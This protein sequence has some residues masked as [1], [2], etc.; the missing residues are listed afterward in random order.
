MSETSIPNNNPQ[1]DEWKKFLL[2]TRAPDDYKT[3]F[4]ESNERMSFLLDDGS[5]EGQLDIPSINS[6]LEIYDYI[7]QNPNKAI[8]TLGQADVQK[9]I[10][11]TQKYIYPNWND[12]KTAKNATK[13][14]TQNYLLKYNIPAYNYDETGAGLGPHIK[15]RVGK[16]LTSENYTTEFGVDRRIF[17]GENTSTNLLNNGQFEPILNYDYETFI[18]DVGEK[19]ADKFVVTKN[20]QYRA[21]TINE[22]GDGSIPT[23]SIYNNKPQDF[24]YEQKLV[25]LQYV[26]DENGAYR[27]VMVEKGEEFEGLDIF[28][29]LIDGNYADKPTTVA[30]Q[31]WRDTNERQE[32]E[33]KPYIDK[34]VKKRETE[35]NPLTNEEFQLMLDGSHPD[36]QTDSDLQEWWRLSPS[37]PAN[38][39]ENLMPSPNEGVPVPEFPAMELDKIKRLN[40]A[41][42]MVYDLESG[43]VM[44]VYYDEYAKQMYLFQEKVEKH[45]KYTLDLQ[46][47]TN[48][49]DLKEQLY[50]RY[51][52]DFADELLEGSS[53]FGAMWET[54][55]VWDGIK[56][57]LFN[58]IDLVDQ[59]V[60]MGGLN[61]S[62]QN[63]V[64]FY[65]PEQYENLS[66]KQYRE[67]WAST[68]W[69]IWAK[70]KNGQMVQID[71][72]D[73]NNSQ[74]MSGEWKFENLDT[75]KEYYVYLDGVQLKGSSSYD[76]LRDAF[77]KYTDEA[78][79]TY[80][81]NQARPNLYKVSFNREL[82]GMNTTFADNIANVGTDI[83]GM[84]TGFGGIYKGFSY[85][86]KFNKLSKYSKSALVFTAH[87]NL[88]YADSEVLANTTF[89]D[90]ARNTMFD[91]SIGYMMPVVSNGIVIT[92]GKL[93]FLPR[94]LPGKPNLPMKDIYIPAPQGPILTNE[95]SLSAL[96]NLLIGSG[97]ISTGFEFKELINE[98]I[99][100]VMA[101][102]PNEQGLRGLPYTEWGPVF[103]SK[104]EHRATPEGMKQ[105]F[106]NYSLMT[107][108][109]SS[110][111]VSR[112]VPK[113]GTKQAIKFNQNYKQRNDQIIKEINLHKNEIPSELKARMKLAEQGKLNSDQ[114]HM[115]QTE[116]TIHR[117]NLLINEGIE[118]QQRIQQIEDRIGVDGKRRVKL[119]DG[120]WIEVDGVWLNQQKQI[121]QIL[122]N[123]YQIYR[124][125]Y[126]EISS[127]DKISSKK[128][129]LVGDE[130]GNL[131][132]ETEFTI[133]GRTNAEGVYEPPITIKL[134]DFIV[135][136]RVGDTIVWDKE[137]TLNRI[138]SELPY[139]FPTG[140]QQKLFDLKKF[141]ENR[142]TEVDKRLY[143]LEEKYDFTQNYNDPFK[144]TNKKGE[145]IPVIVN[146]QKSWEDLASMYNIPVNK[147]LSYNGINPENPKDL[148]DGQQIFLENPSGF[149]NVKIE[150]GGPMPQQ[151]GLIHEL[152]SSLL[153]NQHLDITV[154]PH[155]AFFGTLEYLNQHP[156]LEQYQF[157]EADIGGRLRELT[158]EQIMIIQSEYGL[159]IG[160]TYGPNERVFGIQRG[161]SNENPV[162]GQPTKARVSLSED[163]WA[164]LEDIII[165]PVY[166]N[167][168]NIGQEKLLNELNSIENAFRQSV[169]AYELNGMPLPEKEGEFISGLF[170]FWVWKNNLE[171]KMGLTTGNQFKEA[172]ELNPEFA[173][174]LEQWMPELDNTF[175]KFWEVVSVNANG[176]SSVEMMDD[177]TEA[178]AEGMMKHSPSIP[179]IDKMKW[180]DIKSL[181][182]GETY[183]LGVRDYD[184]IIDIETS[185]SP[186]Q[187]TIPQR[188]KLSN[189]SLMELFP[190]NYSVIRPSTIK[191]SNE[192]HLV[193]YLEL[194]QEA[195]DV[196]TEEILN[197]WT[198]PDGLPEGVTKVEYRNLVL[199]NIFSNNYVDKTLNPKYE[200]DMTITVPATIQDIDAKLFNLLNIVESPLEIRE[201]MK[202]E[203]VKNVKEKLSNEWTG[204]KILENKPLSQMTDKEIEE[205]VNAVIEYQKALLN[206]PTSTL[207]QTDWWGNMI[208]QTMSNASFEIP[209]METDKDLKALFHLGLSI[210]SQGTKLDPNYQNT[211]YIISEYLSTGNIPTVK[212]NGMNMD[213]M[214]MVKNQIAKL[215]S[216]KEIHGS[217]ESTLEWLMMPTTVGDLRKY[218]ID[219]MGY[220]KS[221]A[222]SMAQ[223]P[224]GRTNMQLETYN[225]M[226]FGP[227]IGSMI[228]VQKGLDLSVN[229]LWMSRLLQ[230]ATGDIQLNDQQSVQA[231]TIL[232][233]AMDG[234][235]E[236]LG[237]SIKGAQ[238]ETWVNMKDV[239]SLYGTSRDADDYI[240][241]SNTRRK[242]YEDFASSHPLT[243]VDEKRIRR[244]FGR[245]SVLTKSDKKTYLA[246]GE[247]PGE[248][249]NIKPLKFR[250]PFTEGVDKLQEKFPGGEIKKESF[251]N[252]FN[253]VKGIKKKYKEWYDIDGFI[254][255]YEG[256]VVKID[257]FR[258]YINSRKTNYHQVTFDGGVATVDPQ[259]GAFPFIESQWGR[260]PATSVNHQANRTMLPQLRLRTEHKLFDRFVAP[261]LGKEVQKYIFLNGKWKTGKEYGEANLIDMNPSDLKN[262]VYGMPGLKSFLAGEVNELQIRIK[263]DLKLWF[264]NPMP[265]GESARIAKFRSL[266]R[267][268]SEYI[269][270]TNSYDFQVNMQK[271]MIVDVLKNTNWWTYTTGG[272]YSTTKAKNEVLSEGQKFLVSNEYMLPDF[273]EMNLQRIS[274]RD[275]KFHFRFTGDGETTYNPRSATDGLEL[276]L[277][278]RTV[279]NFYKSLFKNH[280]DISTVDYEKEFINA[281]AKAKKDLITSTFF[282]YKPKVIAFDGKHYITY[283]TNVKSLNNLIK[284]IPFDSDVHYDNM[285][286]ELYDYLMSNPQVFISVNNMD[287][288]LNN[289]G[290][291]DKTLGTNG[292]FETKFQNLDNYTANYRGRNYQ[293][294]LVLAPGQKA[295]HID[296]I[297]K[298]FV[299]N[300]LKENGLT[301]ETMGVDAVLRE[302]NKTLMTGQQPVYEGGHWGIQTSLT[303]VRGSEITPFIWKNGKLQ[304]IDHTYTHNIFMVEELQSDWNKAWNQGGQ[305][306]MEPP[307]V[308]GEWVKLGIKNSISNAVKNGNNGITFANGYDIR[309]DWKQNYESLYNHQ[310][311]M[312]VPTRTSDGEYKYRVDSRTMEVLTGRRYENADAVPDYTIEELQ[313]LLGPKLFEMHKDRLIDMLEDIK[314]G[315]GHGAY[316]P[317]F[318]GPIRVKATRAD[319]EF[320]VPDITHLPKP[321]FDFNLYDKHIVSST[322]KILKQFKIKPSVVWLESNQLFGGGDAVVDEWWDFANPGMHPILQGLSPKTKDGK[323]LVPHIYFDFNKG[324]TEFINKDNFETFK[325]KKLEFSDKDKSTIYNKKTTPV[326]DNKNSGYKPKGEVAKWRDMHLRPVSSVLKG[327]GNPVFKRT[328]RAQVSD[329]MLTSSN[330]NSQASGFVRYLIQL[331][332][333][334]PDLFENMTLALYNGDVQMIEKIM[335]ST[336]TELPYTTADYMAIVNLV[337]KVYN[338]TVSLGTE[339]GKIDNYY[340]RSVKDINGLWD[341]LGVEEKTEFERALNKKEKELGRQ[342][343]KEERAGFMDSFLRGYIPRGDGKPGHT[344]GRNINLVTRDMLPYYEKPYDAML[345]YIEMFSKSNS[346]SR[347]FG[348]GNPNESIGAWV[349]EQLV[350]GNIKPGQVDEVKELITQHYAPSKGLGNFGVNLKNSTYILTMANPYSALTQIGDQT[351]SMIETGITRTLYNDV[352]A[353]LGISEV[354]L[355]DLGINKMMH[356]LRTKNRSGQLVSDFFTMSGLTTIDRLGKEALINGTLQKYRELANTGEYDG[357]LKDWKTDKD[358]S[359]LDEYFTPEEKTQLWEDLQSGE[360]TP[361][362]QKLLLNVIMDWQPIADSEV[363]LAY[364]DKPL[365]YQLKTYTIKQVNATKDNL[366]DD[367]TKHSKNLKNSKTEEERKKNKELLE[368]SVVAF[369]TAMATFMMING[370]ADVSKDALAG[371]DID[372]TDI[373]IEQLYKIPGGSRYIQWQIK[374]RGWGEAITKQFLP[375]SWIIPFEVGADV[376]GREINQWNPDVKVGLMPYIQNKRELEKLKKKENKTNIE[377][378]R[379]E[380]LEKALE[381]P[382]YDNFQSLKYLPLGGKHHYW[383]HGVGHK[384]I[385]LR[386]FSK[387]KENA[388]DWYNSK[389]Y[390]EKAFSLEN[391]MDYVHNLDY[392]LSKNMIDSSYYKNNIERAVNYKFYRNMIRST[393]DW[394]WDDVESY[395]KSLD[396]LLDMNIIDFDTW[397][398]RK[399]TDLN[400]YFEE[401]WQ[402]Q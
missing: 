145:T 138:C 396:Q 248:T 34:Y 59:K 109:H 231:M 368:Q 166:K 107:L 11:L 378:K 86:D 33:A 328:V 383:R 387:I 150:G 17:S 375:P 208:E 9:V 319:F 320:N 174:L 289:L 237:I 316:E 97:I 300:Y 149:Y 209:E 333:F 210:T 191:P 309:L 264:E 51:D 147:L 84:F 90:Y 311:L 130:F 258:S 180:V 54:G 217:Y 100:E 274:L 324:F 181:L 57:T 124:T 323:L 218:L 295:L 26:V 292:N 95:N 87:G 77:D 367:I 113:K 121:L 240:T 23:Q 10:N 43:T 301:P 223:A 20:S 241:I 291:S 148:K 44:P 122:D 205:R 112:F 202:L 287:V 110:Q 225:A 47:E 332:N 60:F 306:T 269:Q 318:T 363:P 14:D 144:V 83:A 5:I 388:G 330:W 317:K 63:I 278:S 250:D 185:L 58:S 46:V 310:N 128:S 134:K 169:Q 230:I 65:A 25:V 267:I 203:Q 234:I 55:N 92:R 125:G 152:S 393:T 82:Y 273:T 91:A 281:E 198:P 61:T 68:R 102:K 362:V 355:E 195:L 105:L 354:K 178:I 211:L 325:I 350:R 373:A 397:Y 228:G 216:L 254:N 385:I 235:A 312:I 238:A 394:G 242:N 154:D 296:D 265:E 153:H 261:I 196:W 79:W 384:K 6:T 256:D 349:D 165:E 72:K 279:E 32:K 239:F 283:E 336:N 222:T 285:A 359:R 66:P 304:K 71:T 21:Y 89:G 176:K 206:L 214:G 142:I 347:A 337:D 4:D 13:T 173:Q 119:Q 340:P 341:M 257:D 39:L 200:G 329:A 357:F 201:N 379:M 22:S 155:T 298:E 2:A 64:N 308:T 179:V 381:R 353:L 197:H 380:D 252:E 400:N 136:K 398:R 78:K 29:T 127:S 246:T 28:A 262:I 24:K 244:D 36:I 123:I 53:F 233:K 249:F 366:I 338:E 343:T 369:F 194:N 346:I 49:K 56:G 290:Y 111:Y 229:D 313:K 183:K 70:D 175:G 189:E 276:M 360:V 395:E 280:K 213:R 348:K 133:P 307:T 401:R 69:S 251:L 277:K 271:Q 361:V 371:R 40:D 334:S 212:P 344:K 98:T 221:Q 227:K 12:I 339:M 94:T 3:I 335:E 158:P 187:S 103:Y 365:W 243:G 7:Q 177:L 93:N 351:W 374:D 96:K 157:T 74:G 376:V 156:G 52:K 190:E 75:Y 41:N 322:E 275:M 67:M 42:Y 263:R 377:K 192:G 270:S 160:G 104:L 286:V 294:T 207:S 297:P 352:K 282:G 108:I 38:S 99:D 326:T 386:R 331:E 140:G 120:E 172:L 1:L 73:M 117:Q 302:Y 224:D 253:K 141:Y 288:I 129:K 342:L 85:F 80:F 139:I 327:Y 8:E 115:L 116:L 315:T 167:L 389:Y 50:A 399:H 199:K 356:E 35:G 236:E 204:G 162:K 30:E 266:N 168:G 321:L 299:D 284:P 364:K 247:F 106:I 188:L 182:E 62:A 370:T 260:G 16:I 137:A 135:V 186:Y 215:N 151:F 126:R 382:W 293:E 305:F 163:V 372:L 358:L 392:A 31:S 272:D 48:L 259:K 15:T 88:K 81:K 114:E 184:K 161:A 220:T 132:K 164:Y 171:P 390:Q 226:M 391:S 146:N 19:E 76:N 193:E 219:V 27:P 118:L 255:N 45:Q 131:S 345:D 143:S 314:T 268:L 159:E 303:S 37:N 402:K 101:G 245:F 170:E 232:N 18:Q